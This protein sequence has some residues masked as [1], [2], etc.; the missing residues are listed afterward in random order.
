MG[1]LWDLY[2]QRK[3]ANEQKR[4]RIIREFLQTHEVPDDEISDGWDLFNALSSSLYEKSKE[5]DDNK[6]KKL[7][8]PEK[9]KE[10]EILELEEWQKDLVREGSYYKDDTW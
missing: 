6:E 8:S 2:I 9:E 4:E 3:K 7:C 1:K 5:F 10:M